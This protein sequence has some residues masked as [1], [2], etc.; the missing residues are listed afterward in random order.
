MS[1]AAR[2]ERL[3]QVIVGPHISEKATALAEGARQI[4]FRVRPD[5]NKTDVRQAVELLFDVKVERVAVARM[6]GKAK[7]FGLR[8]GQRRGWKKAFVKLAPGHDI[9]FMGAE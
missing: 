7:R 3:M 8:T 9:D 5:A 6:P 4:I 2:Q 1:K